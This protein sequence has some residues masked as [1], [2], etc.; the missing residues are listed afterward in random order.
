DPAQPS[1]REERSVEAPDRP[2]RLAERADAGRDEDEEREE[3]HEALHPLVNESLAGQRAED[4]AGAGE[5]PDAGRP[6]LGRGRDLDRSELEQDQKGKD[7]E[8][9]QDE[10]L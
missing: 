3:P 2:D 6:I 7:A 5:Q 9:G 10:D 1:P 8:G 4:D